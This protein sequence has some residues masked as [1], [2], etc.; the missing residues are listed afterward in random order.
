MVTLIVLDGYGFSKKEEGNAVFLANTPFLDKIKNEYPHTLIRASG[1][2]VG[3]KNGQMGNSETGHL[4][5]GAG[6]IMEQD[7]TIIDNEIENGKFFKN[8][9]INNFMKSV[10]KN[11]GNLHL[12]IML[13][14]GGVHSHINH[15]F[16]TIKSA[17]LNGVKNVF[18]H[19]ITDGRDVGIDSSMQFINQ[20]E[21]FCKDIN[22]GK[23]ATIS[24]RY[25]AMDRDKLYDRTEK[26]YRVIVEGEG[27]KFNSAKELIERNYQNGVMDE[28]IVPARLIDVK[29]EK[30]DGI[31]FINFRKDRTKQLTESLI[32]PDFNEF[33]RKSIFSNFIS[34]TNYGDEFKNP[35]AYE[36]RY[37]KN[38]LV[39]YLDKNNKKVAKFSE[40]TKFPHITYFFNGGVEQKYPH[41]EWYKIPAKKCATFDEVPEMSA[42]EVAKKV[43]EIV[44]NSY[45][46]CFINIA[47]CDIVGHTGNL[48]ATIKAVETADKAVEII[49]NHIK[50]LG[51][52]VIVTADHGNSEQMIKRHKVCTTH[53]NNPVDF[54]IVTK[55]PVK[56]LKKGALKDVAPTI[57]DLLNLSKPKEMEG[58]SLITY[59]N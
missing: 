57:L 2:Y 13:S 25:Y 19:A 32:L 15:L 11:N 35:V 55:K 52:D 20:T 16:A 21:K 29:F 24:G 6:R 14:N 18:I 27:E 56:K 47:N 39:E 41:E 59:K 30:N 23:I 51:G 34:M 40:P 53:T 45:D 33:S 26:A 10:V 48:K 3:L 43:V 37:Y 9:T 1:K 12:I 7:L 28:Y 22:L 54:I 17:K 49:V 8:K 4:N 31:F 46:F 44:D 50:S 36:N 42:I 38:T 5:L 58:E